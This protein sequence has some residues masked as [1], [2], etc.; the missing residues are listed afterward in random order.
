MLS[1]IQ[2]RSVPPDAEQEMEKMKLWKNTDQVTITQ[3][4]KIISSIITVL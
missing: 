1:A 4:K 3:I 2:I